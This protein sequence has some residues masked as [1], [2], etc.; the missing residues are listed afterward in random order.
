MSSTKDLENYRSVIKDKNI[1]LYIFGKDDPD[2]DNAQSYYRYINNTINLAFVYVFSCIKEMYNIVEDI[3][4]KKR[5]FNPN[6]KRAIKNIDRIYNGFD[7]NYE[8]IN[9]IMLDVH[10]DLALGAD[11]CLRQYIPGVTSEFNILD[12]S[13]RIFHWMSTSKYENNITISDLI[14]QF[15]RLISSLP[16]VSST[17]LQGEK[18][19]TF[20]ETQIGF[21][22]KIIYTDC[23]LFIQDCGRGYY[24]FYFLERIETKK[25][26]LFLYYSTP[27]YADKYTIV[28]H[29]NYYKENIT[30]DSIEFIL[31]DLDDIELIRNRIT[32]ADSND[33]FNNNSIMSDGISNI[34]TVNYKYLKNLSLYF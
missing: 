17:I 15:K 9:Y 1:W 31:S 28:Y 6:S 11:S 29:D 27:D 8:L 32:N 12:Y 23:K 2:F 19:D 4:E 14:N 22:K 18:C 25:N 20:F 26:A 34:Y 3:E 30:S 5:L 7:V 10:F 21:E 13:P 33:L 24:Q 16:F